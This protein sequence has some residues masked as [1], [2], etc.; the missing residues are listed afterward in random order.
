MRSAAR[1]PATSAPEVTHVS[2]R[3][4][5]LLVDERERFLPYAQFPWFRD[6][7]LR[8]VLNVEQPGRDH[9]RWPALDVDLSVRSIIDP[10]AFPLVSRKAAA[11]R[12]A[13]LRR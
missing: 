4:I 10:A 11:K 9:L 6:A 2:S 1:G 8:D 7:V 3:G 5:W 13:K 12:V